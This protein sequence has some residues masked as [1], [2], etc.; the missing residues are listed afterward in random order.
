MEEKKK[1]TKNDELTQEEIN[2][3]LRGVVHRFFLSLS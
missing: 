1:E 3:L 2:R